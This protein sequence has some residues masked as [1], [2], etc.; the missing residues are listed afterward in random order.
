MLDIVLQCQ[1]NQHIGMD[2]LIVKDTSLLIS[3]LAAGINLTACSTDENLRQSE[4]PL[5]DAPSYRY[6]YL[7]TQSRCENRQM[8]LRTDCPPF[9]LCQVNNTT[10]CTP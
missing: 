3:M 9:Q 4:I 7:N 10:W 5:L 6:D 2:P 8:A 1:N